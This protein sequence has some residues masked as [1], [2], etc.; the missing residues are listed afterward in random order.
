MGFAVGVGLAV[1]VGVDVGVG[2]AVAVGVAIGLSS[3]IGEG[4]C[5]PLNFADPTTTITNKVIAIF[6]G[7]KSFETSV[8]R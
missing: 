7:K 1:A 5:A 8:R 6:I 3:E 2:V 4:S